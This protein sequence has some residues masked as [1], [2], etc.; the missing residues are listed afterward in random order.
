M[1]LAIKLSMHD[2]KAEFART[3]RGVKRETLLGVKAA[4]G[5]V[6][7]EDAEKHV[8]V[9]AIVED[10]VV[11]SWSLFF[12]NINEKYRV[13]SA[14]LVLPLPIN[15]QKNLSTD[16]VYT[17]QSAWLRRDRLGDDNFERGSSL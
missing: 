7:I 15:V 12:G 11:K 9:D 2:A 17:S 1:Q 6:C 4:A 3:L 8:L 14:K 16:N 10:V 5:V 13:Q